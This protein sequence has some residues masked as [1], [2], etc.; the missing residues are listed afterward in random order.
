MPPRASRTNRLWGNGGGDEKPGPTAAG[1]G[2]EAAKKNGK[3]GATT[4]DGG[5]N[6]RMLS[7][8]APYVLPC[9]GVEARER[10]ALAGGTRY[11]FCIRFIHFAREM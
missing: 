5:Y 6:I 2:G 7:A 10:E 8:V 9:L 4:S 3:A 1:V 11:I